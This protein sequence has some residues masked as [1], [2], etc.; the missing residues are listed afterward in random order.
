MLV[1]GVSLFGPVSLS[2]AA[3]AGA[4]GALLLVYATARTGLY[5]VPMHAQGHAFPGKA[6]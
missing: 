2:A 4:L 6:E 1:F 3:F 5:A